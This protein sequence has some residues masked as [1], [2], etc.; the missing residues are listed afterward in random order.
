MYMICK[1]KKKKLQLRDV[2]YKL[3]ASEI[4]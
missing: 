4:N 3:A 2:A 1:T